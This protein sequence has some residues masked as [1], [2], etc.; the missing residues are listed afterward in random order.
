MKLLKLEN[1]SNKTC[2][3]NLNRRTQV[4]KLRVVRC[5]KPLKILH[6]LTDWLGTVEKLKIRASNG[7]L[8]HIVERRSEEP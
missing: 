1:T 5:L 8:A 3:K 6:K 4:R 7:P 2:C